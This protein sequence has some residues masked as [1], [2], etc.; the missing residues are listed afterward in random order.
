MRHLY[1][2]LSLGVLES[3]ARRQATI[4]MRDSAVVFSPHYDDETLGAG[5]TIIRKRKEGATVYLVFMTDGS[6]SHAH[7]MEG[8]RL[9]ELRRNEALQAAASL[10]VNESHVR[11]LNFPET[12]LTQYA[13]EATQRV[14]DLLLDLSCQQVFVPSTLEPL[15]WSADHNVTTEIV[16]RALSR[17]GQHPE[18]LEYLVWFWY[19]WPWVPLLKCGD[20]RRLLK[21]TCRNLF[22]LSALMNLNTAVDIV[23][24]RSQKQDALTKYESQMTRLVVDKWWPVLADVCQGEFLPRF[25]E[26]NEF[27]RTYKYAG[28]AQ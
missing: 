21:L 15:L 24:V 6:R 3:R 9:S 26:S 20:T 17:V 25:F 13:D 14:A 7:A 28:R 2:N 22:G 27:F 18:V 8:A 19:H 10:G 11:F 23:S 4:E 16:F 5:G 1:R 12:R